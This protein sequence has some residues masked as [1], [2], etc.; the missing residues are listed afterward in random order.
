[1]LGIADRVDFMGKVE[2][3]ARFLHALDL[4]TLPS[5][6]EGFPTSVLE[7][8]ASGVPVVATDVGGTGEIIQN[9]SNGLLVPAGDKTALADA[10]KTLGS[11]AKLASKLAANARRTINE[12]FSVQRMVKDYQDL[13]DQATRSLPPM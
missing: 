13:Y 8:M 3:V 12:K 6:E 5:F 4:F 11:S 1:M 9:E 10:I 7:A 2:D